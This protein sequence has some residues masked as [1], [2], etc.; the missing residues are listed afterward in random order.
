[1]NNGEMDYIE[2]DEPYNRIRV[3]KKVLMPNVKHPGVSLRSHSCF[4]P[5]LCLCLFV[6]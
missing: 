3:S 1:M 6:V 4:T 2:V 5:L